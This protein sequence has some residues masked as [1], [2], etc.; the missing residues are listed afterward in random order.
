MKPTRIQVSH[1]KDEGF[2]LTVEEYSRVRSAIA[3][4]GDRL[5]ALTRHV[6]CNRGP[7]AWA[8]NQ[9]W[10]HSKDLVKLPINREIANKLSPGENSWDWLDIPEEDV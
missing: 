10:R 9:D 7:L 8:M 6:G 4:V 1:N 5:C 2:T 3:V